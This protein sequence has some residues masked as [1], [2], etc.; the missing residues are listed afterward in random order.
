MKKEK[1]NSPNVKDIAIALPISHYVKIG[2]KG[3]N[4]T[5]SGYRLPSKLDCFRVTTT[6]M[7]METY[8]GKKEYGN[9]F[10]DE[11]IH[12]E[13]GDKPKIIPIR[14]I[15]NDINL[16]FQSR[17]ACTKNK[18]LFCTGDGEFGKERQSDG[19]T[20]IVD[21]PC[22]R[23][24]PE[25]NGDKN[26]RKG[27]CKLNGSLYFLID[28][29][30]AKLGGM[31][32][33]TTTGYNAISGL[34]ASLRMYWTITNGIL[35]G[36][37]LELTLLTKNT[38]EVKSGTPVKI[39]YVA[40]LFNGPEK[41]I[42]SISYKIME[43]NTAYLTMMRKVE[44][45]AVKCI[46]YDQNFLEKETDEIINEFHPEELVDEI[47]SLKEDE[48]TTGNPIENKK[49]KVSDKI[50]PL[51][52]NYQPPKES[53]FTQDIEVKSA[54]EWTKEAKKKKDANEKQK[55]VASDDKEGR[56]CEIPRGLGGEM[57]GPV[58]KEAGKKANTGTSKKRQ[59]KND[60]SGKGETTPGNVPK[61]VNGVKMPSKGIVE[62]VQVKSVENRAYSGG[63]DQLKNEQTTPLQ[64]G[65][66]KNISIDSLFDDF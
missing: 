21:C 36:I 12:K 50:T 54:E 23:A 9:F 57:A 53:E 7:E 62:D 40:L 19:T 28:V 51:S 26:D 39:H 27:V 3:K 1:G 29:P 55:G 31:A 49:R 64:Q 16:N 63:T 66:D 38:I 35:A 22:Y 37:P 47:E 8:C 41:L 18:K 32:R 14:L 59:V 10:R 20:K 52:E 15:Y 58:N 48:G 56:N 60:S 13:I 24:N 11:S 61:Q 2:V 25:Y 5:A 42:K 34:L 6:E 44:E 45:E 46:N 65:D 4:R 30:G 33:Y 43:K 17:H